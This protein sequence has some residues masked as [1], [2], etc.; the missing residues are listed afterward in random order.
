MASSTTTTTLREQT[1]HWGCVCSLALILLPTRYFYSMILKR[2]A[3]VLCT[4]QHLHI[5][6]AMGRQSVLKH[7]AAYENTRLGNKVTVLCSR[8]LQATVALVRHSL[9]SAVRK[10]QDGNRQISL[11]LALYSD[12]LSRPA[13]D[14]RP[15]Y[16]LPV[17]DLPF[18][19]P[20]SMRNG[21]ESQ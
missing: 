3:F 19:F 11:F 2:T 14:T 13:I 17:N 12:C 8:G 6:Y 4:K 10:L 1:C 18:F 20:H 9:D 15:I 21:P 7:S 5:L 16:S